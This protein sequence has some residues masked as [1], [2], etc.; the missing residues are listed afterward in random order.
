MGNNWKFA[1]YSDL[2]LHPLMGLAKIWHQGIYS[3]G[4]KNN[5]FEI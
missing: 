1:E 3:L 4:M 2:E 5:S